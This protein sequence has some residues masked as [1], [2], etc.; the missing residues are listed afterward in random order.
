MRIIPIRS[1]RTV[2]RCVIVSKKSR[3]RISNC[4]VTAGIVI[5]RHFTR[6]LKM[7]K[8]GKSNT[9]ADA[10]DVSGEMFTYDVDIKEVHIVTVQVQAAD[11]DAALEEV[12]RRLEEEE[13][14]METSL[15]SHTL[16]PDE[17]TVSR[18]SPRTLTV[19][20]FDNTQATLEGWALFNDGELQRIDGRETF[21]SDLQAL[22]HV[23]RRA[24]DGSNY[25]FRALRRMAPGWVDKVMGGKS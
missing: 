13:I 5:W 8:I 24:L 19:E 12:Q 3:L 22:C 16:D 18:V 15:Y 9:E 6:Y 10:A 21:D 17:W 23:Q 11:E 4:G 1:A 7:S 25:H 2:S 14:D 20:E